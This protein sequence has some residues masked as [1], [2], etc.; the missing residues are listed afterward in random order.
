MFNLYR[1]VFTLFVIQW[2]FLVAWF[3]FQ[4]RDRCSFLFSEESERRWKEFLKAL[5]F[6]TAYDYAGAIFF[7][8]SKEKAVKL[9]EFK[10]VSGVSKGIESI[11]RV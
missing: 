6:I 5:N 10:I 11:Y 1:L 3:N 8:F 4:N 9:I 2:N 7:F